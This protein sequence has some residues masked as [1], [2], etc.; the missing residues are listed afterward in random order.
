M[1]HAFTAQKICV[2]YTTTYNSKNENKSKILAIL[3]TIKW[4]QME[5]YF[6][7]VIRRVKIVYFLPSPLNSFISLLTWGQWLE[8]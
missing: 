2:H 5:N 3:F 6:L 1:K 7:K 8:L 4:K